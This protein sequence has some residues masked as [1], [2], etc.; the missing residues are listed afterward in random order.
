MLLEVALSYCCLCRMMF[1]VCACNA[2]L[3]SGINRDLRAE[4]F[5]FDLW[6]D[7]LVN[8]FFI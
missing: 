1:Y 3:F 2:E 7:V 6:D 4:R 8:M 5:H